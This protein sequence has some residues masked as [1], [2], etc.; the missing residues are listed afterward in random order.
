MQNENPFG[1]K[2]HQPFSGLS[3]ELVY[4][5]AADGTSI[6]ISQAA[7][8]LRCNCRCPACEQVLVAK[9]GKKQ[10]HHFAHYNNGTACAHVAETNAHI[11]AK[12][13]LERVKSLTIPAVT[14]E[15]GGVSKVVSPSQ[16]YRFAHARLEKKLGSI[17]PDVVLITPNG[18]KLIVE[19]RVT[20]PCDD[21]KLEKLRKERL[22]AIEID[23]RHYRTSTNR[24]EVEQALLS[25]APR[26]WLSNAKK[27][28]FD[29]QLRIRLANE[30]EQSAREAEARAKR[31]AELEVQKARR[32][33][34]QADRDARRLAQSVR[35]VK[36]FIHELPDA[37]NAIIA[38]FDDVPWSDM[39][40]IGF[41]VTDLVWEAELAAK[42][43]THPNAVDYQEYEPI[44]IKDALRSIAHYIIPG[45]QAEIRP[46]VRV[47]LGSVFPRRRIP[48]EA[49]E[50]F[51][52]HLVGSGYLVPILSGSYHVDPG[53][54]A[55]LSEKV[56]RQAAYEHRLEAVRARVAVVM[57]D[58][59]KVD[60][61]DFEI[62]RWLGNECHFLN[63]SPASLCHLG[64]AR[65]RE[66]DRLLRHIELM[67]EGGP[68]AEELLGLPLE[69]EVTRALN[70]ERDRLL[71]AAANRR[72]SLTEAAASQ[73]EE[74]AHAWLS[75]PSADDEELTRIDQAG[76][77]DLSYQRARRELEKATAMRQA[78]AHARKVALA[79]QEELKVAGAKLMDKEHLDLFLR[80]FHPALGKSPLMYCVDAR[81]L[82]ECLAL[83]SPTRHSGR[84]R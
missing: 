11:W 10:I 20:H 8:G 49:I 65:F 56:R 12:D 16:T 57:A 81:S 17:V 42:Y 29:E 36:G 48:A 54:A 53:Y 23:L 82:K 68:A 24:T 13:V 7:R 67:C 63:A 76:V 1:F 27:A 74:E 73:L 32:E 5:I 39:R 15:H 77:D 26:E 84:R 61:L 75:G 78:A 34:E 41:T 25:K 19:V 28:K 70:R 14:A 37:A 71:R 40:T 43:L 4:G 64:D 18:T 45:F 44:T 83:L 46:S 55:R 30:Q 59:P 9:K 72:Q 38:E 79:C 66:F 21:E 6:H 69:A 2:D 52:D 80:A 47:R 3:D 60:A 33:E 35:T 58:L 22:S 51:F 50:A 31:A 62:D